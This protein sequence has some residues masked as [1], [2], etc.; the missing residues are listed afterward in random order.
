MEITFGKDI[1]PLFRPSDIAAMKNAPNGFDLSSYNDVRIWSAE[2]LN[3]L[4]LGNMPCDG[5]WSDANVSL[6]AQWIT[7]GKL[8]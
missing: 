8:P 7:D 6:F 3:Q 1:A 4:Q 2:I 5:A